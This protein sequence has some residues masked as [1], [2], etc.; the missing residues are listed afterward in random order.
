MTNNMAHKGTSRCVSSN[1]LPVLPIYNRVFVKGGPSFLRISFR[2]TPLMGSRTLMTLA[3]SCTTLRRQT[4]CPIF[5]ICTSRGGPR[6]IASSPTIRRNGV[7]VMSAN[8]ISTMTRWWLWGGDRACRIS[9][10][11]PVLSA[12]TRRPSRKYFMRRAI[13]ESTPAIPFLSPGELTN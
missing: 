6:R 9:G 3:P 13:M 7:S 2:R 11:T 4:G 1:A 8:S 10:T 5:R 12:L